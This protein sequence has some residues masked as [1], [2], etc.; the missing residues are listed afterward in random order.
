MLLEIAL[1]IAVFALTLL[2]LTYTCAYVAD[3]T[4]AFRLLFI[5]KPHSQIF[6]L[7]R[8]LLAG[9]ATVGVLAA[10]E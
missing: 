7:V 8:W 6:R 9:A 5:Q 1:G 3:I 2:S 10:I 4:G